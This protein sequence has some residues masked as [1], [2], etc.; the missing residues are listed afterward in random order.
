MDLLDA[1]KVV[2]PLATAFGGL[3]WKLYAKLDQRMDSLEKSQNK[4][5]LDVVEIRVRT[6]KDVEHIKESI[7]DIKNLLS[8]KHG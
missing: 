2:I 1:L 5:E 8:N 6:Q 3:G 7:D 4:T